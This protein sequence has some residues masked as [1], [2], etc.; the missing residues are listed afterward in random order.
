MER[1]RRVNKEIKDLEKPDASG[2]D[3]SVSVIPG[4]KFHFK[5]HLKGPSDTPYEGGF[6]VV[7]IVLPNEYPFAPPKMKFD[8][9]LWHPNVSSQTGAICLGS[10]ARSLPSSLRFTHS[11]IVFLSYVQIFLRTSGVPP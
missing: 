1:E 3:I 9:K 10:A 6:F 4:E 2:S 5:G 7:D 11:S 8:T